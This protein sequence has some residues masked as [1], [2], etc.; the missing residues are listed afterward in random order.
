MLSAALDSASAVEALGRAAV[1]ALAELCLIDI[2]NSGGKLNR[3][4][5]RST[6]VE[7]AAM[8]E[9]ISPSPETPHPAIR[10]VQTGEHVLIERANDN[11]LKVIAGNDKNFEMLRERNL[12]W[13]LS[14][15][16]VARSSLGAMT[17]LAPEPSYK[18]QYDVVRDVAEDLA[19]RAALALDNAKLFEAS[20]DMAVTLQRSL[21]PSALPTIP[22]LDVAARY[23]AGG[24]GAEVGGDF[25]DL[26]PTG[27]EEG[28]WAAVIGDVCGK[29]AEAAALSALAR[30]TIRAANVILR[31]PRRILAFLNQLVIQG[32]YSERFITVAYCRMRPVGGCLQVT[33][34]RAGHPPP[35]LLRTDGT[36]SPQGKPGTLIGVI[37]DPSLNDQVILLRPGEALVLYTDGLTEAMGVEGRFGQSRLETELAKCAGMTADEIADRLQDAVLSFQT[38]RSHD[39]LAILVIRVE[40]GAKL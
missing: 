13:C 23:Q 2:L 5:A 24:E 37:P 22:G 28:D 6:E 21:M 34:G 18:G 35:M 26:F 4:G 19:R 25:Y 32:G 7:V 29:G 16:V 39:D 31:K 17:L 40:P 14:V 20:R 8:L 15:P 27:S 12:R 38:T 3:M 10:A 30:H 1:P 33:L 11:Q 9:G 36:V